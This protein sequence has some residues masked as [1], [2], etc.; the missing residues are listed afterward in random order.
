MFLKYLYATLPVIAQSCYGSLLVDMTSIPQA[1]SRESRNV[2]YYDQLPEEKNSEYDYNRETLLSMPEQS[3]LEVYEREKKIRRVAA[4]FKNLNVRFCFYKRKVINNTFNYCSNFYDYTIS[5]SRR[6]LSSESLPCYFCIFYT[7]ISVLFLI[8]DF[9]AQNTNTNT[10]EVSYVIDHKMISHGNTQ[11]ILSENSMP[12]TYY[13]TTSDL[14]EYEALN[15]NINKLRDDLALGL[16]YSLLLPG[17]YL[18]ISCICWGCVAVGL[19]TTNIQGAQLANNVPINFNKNIAIHFYTNSNT[20][21]MRA[22]ANGNKEQI[23]NL[24]KNGVDVNAKNIYGETALMFASESYK[25]KIIEALIDNKADI[26]ARSHNR[27]TAL[28]IAINRMSQESSLEIINTGMEC[29]KLLI[30]SKSN[31]FDLF[32]SEISATEFLRCIPIGV[33]M[34]EQQITNLGILGV[35]EEEIKKKEIQLFT[36]RCNYFSRII[37]FWG[38]NLLRNINSDLVDIIMDFA[39][40]TNR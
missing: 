4:I 13:S 7:A 17:V 25:K 11:S 2:V 14:D 20:D 32:L 37:Y 35:G 8:L 18:C 34:T 26:E 19:Y 33:V 28:V 16:E 31:L 5:S 36:Q 3:S 29:I 21:L 6:V 9:N 39:I 38:D 1:L 30:E 10:P 22:S 23:E 15:Y 27:E 12:T 40:Q 24:I